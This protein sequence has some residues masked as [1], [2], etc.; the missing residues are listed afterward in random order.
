MTRRLRSILLL[1]SF[2]LL[3][4]GCAGSTAP[5][6]APT[7]AATAAPAVSGAGK[8]LTVFAAASL[9][10]SF[11][12]IGTAFTTKSGG[13]KVTYNF[14][15][16]NTLRAQIEQGAR[17]DVFASANET[18]MNTLVKGSF[19]T[20]TPSIFARNRLVVIL[21]KANPGKIQ[22]FQDL[23]N[24]GLKIVAA[25]PSVPVGGYMLQMLDKMDADSS[26]GAGF[27]DKFMKN[28]ISQETDVKQVVAKVQLG[29][30]DAGVVYSTDVTPKVTPDVQILDVPDAFNVIAQYPIA[31]TK[32][33]KEKDL[34]QA[35]VDYVVGTD[36][37]AVMK[38]Y[39]FI[40][41]K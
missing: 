27:K 34:G 5:A 14:G 12:E 33:A 22:K 31:V 28:V 7:T 16:S 4:A 10:D 30:G 1:V 20:A 37:Q 15:G 25:G 6:A 36:G 8:E 40:S 11:N 41:P 35:F 21:P 32:D 23:G 2:G 38:K 24:S 19:V 39:N 29:E 3:L 13:A 26:F 18:E 17:A 9:T